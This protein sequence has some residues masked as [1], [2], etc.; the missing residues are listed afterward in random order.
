[1]V[2][3]PGTTSHSEFDLPN[4]FTGD[5][6]EVYEALQYCQQLLEASGVEL[7]DLEP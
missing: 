2:P 4:A 1:M 7:E 3:P 6:H 5:L